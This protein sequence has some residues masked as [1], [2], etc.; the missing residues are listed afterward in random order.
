M[1]CLDCLS[2]YYQE[3]SLEYNPWKYNISTHARRMRAEHWEKCKKLGEVKDP[4]NLQ[5]AKFPITFCHFLSFQLLVF[6]AVWRI[7]YFSKVWTW[8]VYLIKNQWGDMLKKLTMPSRGRQCRTWRARCIGSW[9]RWPGPSPPSPSSSSCSRQSESKKRESRRNKLS[10]IHG[11]Q[12]LSLFPPRPVY[13]DKC[14]VIFTFC[15]GTGTLNA[16]P[17]FLGSEEK[18]SQP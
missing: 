6:S 8:N 3:T 17:H 16:L 2:Q 14:S 10:E 5:V 18:N 13:I 15:E 1:L 12:Y 7:M 11:I 4:C 9:S